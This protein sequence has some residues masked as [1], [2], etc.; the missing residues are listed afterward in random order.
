MWRASRAV[1]LVLVSL[2][3]SAPTRPRALAQLAPPEAPRAPALHGSVLAFAPGEQGAL[4]AL[5]PDNGTLA[6]LDAERFAVRATVAVGTEPVALLLAS[7][8]TAYVLDRAESALSEYSLGAEGEEPRLRR[9]VAVPAEPTALALDAQRRALY[10]T[11]AAAATLTVLDAD[12]LS[13]RAR[14]RLPRE[15]RGLA[16]DT[17]R[18]RA[19][20]SHLVGGA[21][22]VVE[23]SSL[24]RR[25]LRLP[26]GPDAP[27]APSAADPP[28]PSLRL[29]PRRLAAGETL[30]RPRDT[31]VLAR[32]LALS[33]DGA[34]LYVAHTVETTN[35]ESFSLS[36]DTYYGGVGGEG[37]AQPA[38]TVSVLDLEQE[39]WRASGALSA[40]AWVAAPPPLQDVT[41]LG[42]RARDGRLLATAQGGNTLGELDPAA[43]DPAREGHAV[44]LTSTRCYGPAGGATRSDGL[45]VV[46]CRFEHSLRVF[47]PGPSGGI[48]RVAL[49]RERLDHLAARGRELFHLNTVAG[50]SR[51]G[52]ACS[53]CHPE[54]RE[55]G[56]VWSTVRGPMQTPWLAG[57]IAHTAP[58]G[59][60][61][62][63]AS[64]EDNVRATAR[65]L[66]GDGSLSDYEVQALA[67]YMLRGM[68]SPAREAPGEGAQRGARLYQNAGCAGC[69]D[70]ARDFADGEV[71]DV[72]TGRVSMGRLGV[73]TPSLR[74]VGLT[75]P[76]FH[77]GRYASLE[78]WLERNHEHMGQT[79]T[80]TERERRDLL[81]YLR[82]L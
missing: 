34:R 39:H 32:A 30:H 77:D 78:Q 62:Q 64:L 15:P 31:S 48:L 69:H 49:G 71:H 57:R 53:T 36:F 3:C 13:V 2:G 55:D 76:Y 42:F 68:R 63:H 44:S 14:V 22:S 51:F 8:H 52:F 28:A 23:L 70:P 26:L 43:P 9:R 4:L 74:F 7:P 5:D 11:S 73:D 45:T 54:G 81:D 1:P 24:E 46:L 29:A 10:V 82:A 12:S 25:S 35:P 6:V 59:W 75:P 80:L 17:L 65:R 50:V 18:G 16:V 38:T 61:G 58:Y 60:D 40:S 21:L 41:W 66:G 20:V 27:P 79:S 67:A 19:F 72:G 33:P 37:V 47:Q 56:V